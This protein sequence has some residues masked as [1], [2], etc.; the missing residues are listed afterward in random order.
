MLVVFMMLSGV[1]TAAHSKHVEGLSMNCNEC[2]GCCAG[3]K[4]VSAW[5]TDKFRRPTCMFSRQ[6]AKSRVPRFLADNILLLEPELPIRTTCDLGNPHAQVCRLM[7]TH[8]AWCM[9]HNLKE[10]PEHSARA[11]EPLNISCLSTRATEP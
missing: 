6:A 8:H 10:R 4:R 11:L 3:E 9:P 2:G 5:G 7:A 1:L